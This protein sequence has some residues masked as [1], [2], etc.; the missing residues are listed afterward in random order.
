[1]KRRRA[2]GNLLMEYDFV[3][4]KRR[5]DVELYLYS[6]S[7]ALIERITKHLKRNGG[8]KFQLAIN[9]LLGKYKIDTSE[10]FKI[11]P[12]FQSSMTQVLTFNSI[13]DKLYNAERVILAFFDGFIQMGSGWFLKE[14]ILLRLSIYKCNPFGGCSS[15]LPISKRSILNIKC[16]DNRCFL[17]CILASFKKCRNANRYTSYLGMVSKM[18]LKGLSFPTKL[19]EIPKFEKNNGLTINVFGLFREHGSD[20]VPFPMY[21]SSSF[22]KDKHLKHV[23]LLL[24]ENHYMLIR[25][26]GSF[27][28]PF[29]WKRSRLFCSKCLISFTNKISYKL[30]IQADCTKNT[31]TGQSYELPVEGSKCSFQNLSKQIKNHFIIY[32]DF[33]TYNISLNKEKGKSVLKSKH[34]L[35]AIGAILLSKYPEYSQPPFIYIGPNAMQKFIDYIYQKRVEISY[36]FDNNRKS[37]DLTLDDIKHLAKQTSCYLCRI[38]FRNTGVRKV[39]DHAHLGREGKGRDVNYTC[40][41][42]NLT[43]SSI[44]FPKFKI[45]VVMHNAMNYDMHFIVQSIYK[46]LKVISNEAPITIEAIPRSSEKL[47]TIFLDNFSFIDSFQFLPS[48][49]SH[50]AD[51]LSNKNQDDFKEIKKYF[52][53]KLFYYVIRKGIMCYDYI[54]SWEK[55]KKRRLPSRKAFFN[56]LSNKHISKK[57]YKFALDMFKFFGCETIKDYLY[58][59]L[60]IDVL[61]L[62]D[63]F[64]SFREQSLDNYGLDPAKYLT[65][66]S[67]SYDAMLKFTNV[68]CN[69]LSEIDM[70]N[71]FERGIRGGITNVAKRFA[72]CE[73]INQHIV[74]YDCNNLYGYSMTQSL[75]LKDFV[76]VNSDDYN[77]FKVTEISD[78]SPVGYVLEVTL[79]YPSDLHDLHD[80]FPLAPEKISIDYGEL[81]PYAK[82]VLKELNLDYKKSGT[83]LI[84]TLSTKKRYIVHYRTLKLYL[85][86]GLRISKIHRILSF[87]QSCWMK[88]YI[89]FNNEKRK[90]ATSS[91]DKEFFKLMNNSTFGKCMENVKR[92]V[93]MVLTS[94]KKKCASLIKRP[95]FH[96]MQIF[97]TNF[98]GVQYKKARVLLDKPIFIGFTILDL[99]K[100]HMFDFHYNVMMKTF[101]LESLQLLYTDTDSMMYKITNENFHHLL[102]QIRDNFDF[103]NMDKK[104]EFYSDIY[105]KV[106]GKFKDETAGKRILE[107]VGLRPKMYSILFD[108]NQ[109]IKRVKG[110]KRSCVDKF[111]HSQFKNVLFNCFQMSAQFNTIRSFKHQVYTVEQHK[112]ALS[113]FEDKRWLRSNGVDSFAY[114][115]YRIKKRKRLS[116]EYPL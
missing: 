16:K 20:Y 98:V 12:W 34:A 97:D 105:T 35:N 55:L 79:M 68:R 10:Y 107:F 32:A 4:K 62:A 2:L 80:M 86:L 45:P 96:S 78:D 38:P 56:S 37:L 69:L 50:L 5:V 41:R 48:S 111:L 11:K 40:N 52:D 73:N 92:R 31:Y 47:L 116:S 89:D 51:L 25:N 15:I 21:I 72:K 83:K 13:K 63:V 27:V 24:Y 81:S 112:I 106:L 113:P 65:A 70:Y 26:L 14:I 100:M 6:K 54:D 28:S 43:F 29:F 95:T 102:Y 57:D 94:N 75:P 66:P 67:L 49:L 33:E 101:G 58:Q 93:K 108:N 59:Y 88:S 46:Y 39:I 8:L 3:P 82:F 17:Y 9:V 7:A 76:W 114:G 109:V 103:S 19:S 104:D 44:V 53:K 30:H 61:L 85:E 74:Y 115:N 110:I 22:D 90:Q 84:T 77:S 71:F 87:K 91:F 36:I 23:N 42:C 60:K 64:E 18:N 1:M 99:S